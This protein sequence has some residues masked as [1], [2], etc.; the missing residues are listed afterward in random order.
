MNVPYYIG[1]KASRILSGMIL[2]A[3][4][5][6]RENLP[7]TGGFILASN[8][9]AYYDP[10]FVG[11][12]VPRDIYFFAKEELFENHVFSALLQRVNALPVRRG[13]IDRRALR[14]AVATIKGGNGLTVFPEGTRSRRGELLDPKPGVGIIARQAECPI[15]PA[16]LSG[17][18]KLR[19][20][21]QGRQRLRLIYGKPLPTQWVKSFP[22][23]K[24]GYQ[25]IA[26][27]IMTEI[28]RLKEAI[29]A[30]QQSD[31]A[32]GRPLK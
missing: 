11:C 1:W 20:C 21:L 16:Y 7:P 14:A 27:G 5:S 12:W 23:S 2:R 15:V 18:D 30:E 28:A 26:R 25:G 32:G 19:R 13:T 10:L 22:I 3:R 17:T 9:V 24:D 31:M 4:V 8:H 29:M 6:G